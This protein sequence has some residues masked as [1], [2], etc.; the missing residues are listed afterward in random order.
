MTNEVWKDIKFTDTDGTEYDYT[1]L[2]QVSNMGRVKSLNYKH[3]GKIGI[4]KHDVHWN[5][6]HMVGLYK[7]GHEKR[8]F[9][10]RLVAF[11]FIENSNP[12]EWTIVNHKDENPHNNVWTNLEWCDHKYNLN[13]GTCQ[14]RRVKK[15]SGENNPCFGKTYGENPN[16]KKVV[17]VETGKV[18]DSMKEASEWM[19]HAGHSKI[20]ACCNGKRKTA[21]KHPL[22]GE[23]LHWMY[24]KDYESLI[25]E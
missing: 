25:N 12:T 20:S 15:Q 18:F 10:H 19:G 2:Y 4:R 22:T 21:G 6:H 3:T 24:L 17:C 23:K 7:N 1:G 13:Y 16:A 11:M 5:E 8:F 14:E 9:V